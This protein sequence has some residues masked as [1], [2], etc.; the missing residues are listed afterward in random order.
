M[1]KAVGALYVSPSLVG[2]NSP[3]HAL[4]HHNFSPRPHP[5]TFP[6]FSTPQKE[7]PSPPRVSH[8]ERALPF[9]HPYL[10]TDHSLPSEPPSH[11]QSNPL[12]HASPRPHGHQHCSRFLAG[13]QHNQCNPQSQTSRPGVTLTVRRLV[14]QPLARQLWPLIPPHLVL[15]RSPHQRL[16]RPTLSPANVPARP[17]QTLACRGIWAGRKDVCRGGQILVWAK[18]VQKRGDVIVREDCKRARC[19]FVGAAGGQRWE[20]RWG[21][22]PI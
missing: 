12:P 21:I 10:Q 1:F 5:A 4:S 19:R 3:S 2:V 18:V 14:L 13:K 6:L 22:R 16:H 8:L 7:P 11:Y 9:H 20:K 17:V 15:P